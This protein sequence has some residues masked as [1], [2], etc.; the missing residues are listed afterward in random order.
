M[1][2]EKGRTVSRSAAFWVLVVVVIGLV[3]GT[4]LAIV[5]PTPG[6]PMQGPPGPGHGGG[7]PPPV[8]SIARADVL[9][10]TLALVLLA[11]LVGVY[12]RHYRS[13]RAPYVLGL[14]VFLGAL[15]LETLLNSPI[16]FAGFGISPGSLGPFLAVSELVMSGALAIFLYLSLL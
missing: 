5:I 3:A 1:S 4:V 13:T 12:A 16:L 7:P 8:F 14:L 6:G 11:A 15:F 9:F 2:E 10:S